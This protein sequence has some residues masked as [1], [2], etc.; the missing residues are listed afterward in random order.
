MTS[1][2]YYTRIEYTST[3]NQHWKKIKTQTR[4]RG[5]AAT[6]DRARRA[7]RPPSAAAAQRRPPCMGDR[8]EISG[9]EKK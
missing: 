7:S 2:K 1:L 3:K 4:T 9:E 6:V 5:P 8:E